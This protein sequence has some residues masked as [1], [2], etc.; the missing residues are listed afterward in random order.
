MLPHKL[1]TL[2]DHERDVPSPQTALQGHSLFQL[3]TKHSSTIALE[4]GGRGRREGEGRGGGGER[5]GRGRG[6]G[7]GGKREREGR[8]RG[9]EREERRDEEGQDGEGRCIIPHTF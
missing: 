3:T 5:E 1:H 8:G 7:E 2:V 4:E 6:E 9:G